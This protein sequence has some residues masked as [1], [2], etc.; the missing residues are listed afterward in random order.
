MRRRDYWRVTSFILS[1][2]LLKQ[3]QIKCS[4]N[5][6]TLFAGNSFPILLPNS[7]HLC[8]FMSLYSW[9]RRNVAGWIQ[10]C[11]SYMS[12]TAQHAYSMLTN[13]QA[14]TDSQPTTKTHWLTS[15]SQYIYPFQPQFHRATKCQVGWMKDDVFWLTLRWTKQSDTVKWSVH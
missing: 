12:T 2:R 11:I 8:S 9:E 13:R 3:T 15:Y 1:H 7:P 10:A 5:K 14:M 6:H 4:K